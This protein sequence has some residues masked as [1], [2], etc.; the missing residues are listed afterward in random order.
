MALGAPISPSPVAAPVADRLLEVEGLTVR[1]IRPER[2]VYAVNRVSFVVQAGRT[3]AV[4]GE[5]GSG[6]TVMSRAI[7]GLLP[8]YAAVHGSAR[9]N[10]VELVGLAE[11]QLR[12]HRGQ[13]VAMVFQDSG[14]SLNPTM[15]IGRQIMEAVRT[16]SS[17]SKREA[18]ERAIEL[19][20]LVRLPAPKQR[21]DEYPMQLSGGM[22]Q[23]VMIAM[24]ISCTPKLLIADEATTALD[25]TTQAQIM[26]L[27]LDLQQRFN[28]GL[29][30]I[31]HDMGVA[32]SYTD[33]VMVM[34]GGRIVERA[35]TKRLFADVRMPYTRVLLDA[36]PRSD[37]PSHTKLPVVQGRPPD[38]SAA[39]TS[40]AFHPRCPYAQERCRL[41]VPP[42]VEGEERHD[43]ACFFPLVPISSRGTRGS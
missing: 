13:D 29:L 21:F 35:A 22:R 8:G 34:Y 30:V 10:G 2:T 25:V 33:E 26:E 23:R 27:L 32:A 20:Q 42:L 36:V 7:M 11:R 17:L 3:T 39:P 5:S 1:F 15:R 16:H 12:S 9:L 40:C 28:M 14:R 41:E 24:A 18:R 19:L 43:W 38:L 4:I 31:S 6:K 37:R